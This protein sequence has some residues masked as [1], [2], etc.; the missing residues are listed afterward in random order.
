M[1]VLLIR[2]LEQ[3]DINTRLPESINKAKGTLPPLGL[4]YMASF[5]EKYGHK[6]KILDAEILNLTSME[7]RKIILKEKADI[8]G[9]TCMTSTF[10]GALEAARFAK[11]SG[12]IVVLG[13]PH[14]N[15]F[16]K[17]SVSSDYVDYGIWGEGEETM[18][19][20]VNALEKMKS[21]RQIGKIKGLIYKKKEKIF[22]NPPR[23]IENLDELPFPAW[24]LLPVEKYGAIIAE[25]PL[26]TMI[27]TRGCPFQCG[28]CFKQPSDKKYRVRSAKNVVDEIEYC[29]KRYGIKEVMFYDDTLTLDKKH[30]ENM[31]NEIIN[32]GI[33][34]K[35]EGPTRVD[36]VDEALLRLMKKAGCKLLRLGVESGDERILKVMNKQINLEK[37]KR[38]FKIAEKV[39][40]ETFAYF[41]IGYYSDTPESMNKTI[42][43]AAE[44]NAD[45]AMF[46][47]ATPYPQTNLFDLAAKD[48]LIDKDYWK[49]Y[50]AGEKV[51]RMPYLVKDA[52]KWAKQAY[53][54][55]YFRP[56]FILKKVR[57]LNSFHK[58]RNYI[59][60]AKSILFYN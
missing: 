21:D 57:N 34:I 19:E 3:G 15:A 32:R 10:P 36:C 51:G 41:I 11:E 22:I 39:G 46:T 25:K 49:K 14:L 55:F 37:V 13:G 35:W 27:T 30:I 16:P 48:N 33:K 7:S 59:I 20:L 17:E 31:C 23:I 56:R 1:K 9:I 26:V 6:V 8:V 5:L 54:R 53:R 58:L 40:I 43:F 38:A 12:A 50:T 47:I 2:Y 29:I 24:H 42:N 18:L 52:D 60:G 28:F 44:L 4:A 45:W